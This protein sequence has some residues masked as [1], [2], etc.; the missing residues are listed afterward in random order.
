MRRHVRWQSTFRYNPL[1]HVIGTF[2]HPGLVI[3]FSGPQECPGSKVSGVFAE[4]GLEGRTRDRE[5]H[6]VAVGKAN[7]LATFLIEL[8]G[9]VDVD[10]VLVERSCSR[11]RAIC[12]ESRTPARRKVASIAR[13]LRLSLLQA[14]A[15]TACSGVM[16]T[17]S[18]SGADLTVNQNRLA[19]DIG[20]RPYGVIAW[21][22]VRT[23]PALI[24]MIVACPTPLLRRLL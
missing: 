20:T 5:T 12:S 11:V 24:A 23:K 10:E 16:A 4:N 17:A 14:M 22:K 7:G 6:L 21:L 8:H 15:A 19:W 1:P 9:T 13:S 3:A 18:R 2:L